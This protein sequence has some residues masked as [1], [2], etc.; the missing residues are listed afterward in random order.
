MFEAPSFEASGTGVRHVRGFVQVVES[1]RHELI[2]VGGGRCPN[3]PGHA[4]ALELSGW[5]LIRFF[6]LVDMG[7]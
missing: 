3:G 2:V 7:R 4:V 1:W 5:P 6:R